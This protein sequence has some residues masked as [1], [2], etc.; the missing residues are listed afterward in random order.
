MLRV[1]AI[2]FVLLSAGC[3]MPGPAAPAATADEVVAARTGGLAAFVGDHR[4]LLRIAGAPA[5]REVPMRLLVEPL[6]E[7]PGRFRWLLHYAGQ[8]ERDYRLLV[9]DP[10]TGACRIDEQNGIE[11]AARYHEGELVAVFVVSGQTLVT[12]YRRVAA[13]VEFALEAFAVADG[14]AT[15]HGVTTL[16]KVALQRALLVTRPGPVPAR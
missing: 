1:L 10:A 12:R 14:V 16:P 11:L 13:G 5:D 15:G 3:A 7:A 9:D 4:G 6:P 8:P 2:V